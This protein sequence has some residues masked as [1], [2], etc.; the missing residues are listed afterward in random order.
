MGVHVDVL[1]EVALA[2]LEVAEKIVPHLQNQEVNLAERALVEKADH[3]TIHFSI[4]QK[5]ESAK[6]NDSHA[7]GSGRDQVGLY[8]QDTFSVSSSLVHA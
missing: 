8:N 6:L 3:Q 1:A 7:E 2:L 4:Y 5:K